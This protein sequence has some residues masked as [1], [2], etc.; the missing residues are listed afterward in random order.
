LIR[1]ELTNVES[2]RRGEEI[3]VIVVSVMEAGAEDGSGR[4]RG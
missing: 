3:L 1:D 4:G 2:K